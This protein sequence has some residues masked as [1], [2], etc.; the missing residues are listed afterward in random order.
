M[1]KFKPGQS[2]NPG[3][4][5]AVVRNIQ[6]HR[7]RLAVVAHQPCHPAAPAT[8]LLIGHNPKSAGRERATVHRSGTVGCTRNCTARRPSAQWCP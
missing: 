7:H 4:R 1:A 3:G 8:A 2:G 6:E 5:P